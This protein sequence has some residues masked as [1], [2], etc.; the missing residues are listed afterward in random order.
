[1]IYQMNLK[2]TTQLNNIYKLFPRLPDTISIITSTNMDH[3]SVLSSSKA[4]FDGFL[5]CG[6]AI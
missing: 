2:G 5:I 6:G 1:M 4:S 3:E